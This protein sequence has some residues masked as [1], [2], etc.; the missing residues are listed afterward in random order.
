MTTNLSP[1]PRVRARRALRCLVIGCSL[2][3]CLRGW[4]QEPALPDPGSQARLVAGRV[5][6]R[7]T[8]D[9]AERVQQELW[10]DRPF[11]DPLPSL[12]ADD[13][14]RFRASPHPRVEFSGPQ[15]AALQSSGSAAA[16]G[17][18]AVEAARAWLQTPP[19]PYAPCGHAY[20]ERCERCPE[21][22]AAG[23]RLVEARR[24]C[25]LA[26]AISGDARYA[27]AAWAA[28]LTQMGHFHR[29]GV[30][31]RAYP[32]EAPWDEGQELFDALAAWDLLAGWGEL[33]PADHALVLNYLRRLGGR[34]AY[35]V[36]LSPVVGLTEATLTC[37][38]GIAAQVLGSVP[39][40]AHWRKLVAYRLDS[41]MGQFL[42]DGGHESLS[43]E[44]QVRVLRV[45]C[46][47]A[48]ARG[49]DG[50]ATGW[51]LGGGPYGTDLE[52][53]LDW[54]A[55]VATP[56]REL[57]A[58]GDSRRLDLG[59]LEFLWQAAAALGRGDWMT[60]W[61]LEPDK[62]PAAAMGLA[63]PVAHDPANTAALLPESGLGV[64]RDGWGREDG[65]L[66]LRFGA[67]GEGTD[68][69][70]RL[71]FELYAN[72]QPWV[73]DPGAPPEGAQGPAARWASTTA[74]HNTVEVDGQSQ[75]PT[76]GAATAWF[77]VPS[78]DV[79]AAEQAGYP[80]LV[81]RRTVLH[82]RRGYTLIC[83]EVVNLSGRERTLS[84][85]AHVNGRRES[86]TTGRFVFWREGKQGLSV[87]LPADAGLRGVDLG[88]GPCTGA[89]GVAVAPLPD[90][91][92][93]WVPGGDG[94]GNIPSIALHKVL[95]ANDRTTYWVLLWP[96]RGAEPAVS[97][98][99]TET[100]G[101]LAAEIRQGDLRDRVVI[102][103]RDA[104]AG[105]M[106]ALGLVTDGQYGYVRELAGEVTALEVLGGDSLSIQ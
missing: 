60:A 70:D 63:L 10:P 14:R 106:R 53:A 30:F 58:I 67:P 28:M 13:L 26:Y 81:Q 3:A 65:Y 74:A 39:E 100:A 61:G 12:S 71:S 77:S 89:P 17:K 36:E 35:A 40:A 37:H 91:T 6:E 22:D 42:P 41:V 57:P 76:T 96:F 24:A 23:A 105:M 34:V 72:G 85:L 29:W 52:T 102:R 101:V 43:G 51:K 50:D 69:A 99:T 80:E 84:W 8:G 56:A 90:G 2:L 9:G 79:L 48:Q 7:L 31:R 82:A 32:W 86:G 94:W 38:L 16:A 5:L 25:A 11:A 88:E 59:G 93:P 83:D 21:V 54:L 78:C 95:R 1:I 44:T 33:T 92:V 18:A 103:R 87:V 19:A 68:H 55:Q 15:I 104:A 45:L 64:L 75:Q 62:A 66:A 47:L 49:L 98:R 4:G 27:R 46:R 73:L 97:L 20:A